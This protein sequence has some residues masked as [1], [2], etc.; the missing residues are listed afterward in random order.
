MSLEVIPTD[1]VM[2]SVVAGLWQ[3]QCL[4]AQ[5]FHGPETEAMNFSLNTTREQMPRTW[6]DLGTSQPSSKVQPLWKRPWQNY[7]SVPASGS[8]LHQQLQ[9]REPQ[10]TEPPQN[11]PHGGYTV[12]ELFRLIWQPAW[13]N[14]FNW[15]QAQNP[16]LQ[17]RARST[18]PKTVKNYFSC[19]WLDRLPNKNIYI[20][21][22][23]TGYYIFRGCF[24][25]SNC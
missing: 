10:A 4:S 6:W 9:E 12:D 11:L 5:I 21:I 3:W 2:S 23:S 18:V 7:T 22:I 19:S 8:Q 25:A 15:L 1:P 14:Y 24:S 17:L 16:T 20:H 13:K